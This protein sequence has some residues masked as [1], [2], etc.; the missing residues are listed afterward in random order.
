MSDYTHTYTPQ[1]SP[2]FLVWLTLLWGLILPRC[3]ISTLF[4]STHSI[5][6]FIY[7]DEPGFLPSRLLGQPSSLTLAWLPLQ[8]LPETAHEHLTS[9]S[10]CL[11]S[12]TP[13]T[14]AKIWFS[15]EFYW[16][17]LHIVLWWI[18]SDTIMLVQ[19]SVNPDITSSLISFSFCFCF[20]VWSPLGSRYSVEHRNQ[21]EG[22]GCHS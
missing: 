11:L 16:L 19:T 1:T 22:S 8:Y 18:E 15:K 2:L 17:E 5:F 3:S 7:S 20:Q 9:L 12:I 10:F 4:Y 14:N 21:R 13:E 6:H